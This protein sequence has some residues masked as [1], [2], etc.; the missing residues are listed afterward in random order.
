MDAK[1]SRR[2]SRSKALSRRL[3]VAVAGLR[4]GAD[5]VPIY[6]HHPDVEYVGIV[7]PERDKLDGVGN[8]FGVAR[9]HTDL[10]EAIHSGAY[11]AVHLVTPIPLHV[12]QSLAALQAGLHCACAV[13]MAASLTD[14][15]KIVT[16]QRKSRLNYMMME[17]AVYTR[18]F[19]YAR[20]L[21][22]SGQLGRI[23][24]LRG[25]HYQD[26]EGWPTYW[27]GLPPMH[28]ATHAV[29]PGFALANT[30]AKSVCC[31]G[32]GAMRKS[33]HRTY[34]N[35]FPVETAL[36][37][38]EKSPLAMEV[39]RSLFQTARGYAESFAVYGEKMTFEWPQLENEAPVVFALGKAD[40]QR[41]GA[42]VRSE[43]IQP[44]DRQDLLPPE[45]RR[46]T[47]RG[48][49][50]PCGP[51][52]P[53]EVGGGHHGSHPH[54]VHE[55]VRSIVEGR[56]PRIDAVTAAQWTAAGICA[57]Q[58]AMHGGRAVN[59]PSFE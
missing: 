10:N 41:R 58:S 1:H 9:R 4:F 24:L 26:M 8:R 48:S 15:R 50:N 35:P 54:L 14:M 45:I 3:R 20:D 34:G 59:V 13:P 7:E 56:K 57:H 46:F 42:P 51:E 52:K 39:T 33:L 17:T 30:H 55:F 2:P 49:Y 12:P 27:M 53:F 43:R 6:L 22:T 25:S 5:F 11:D 38:L 19:L 37:E 29:A 18:P 36:F 23:Q 31:L 16:A 28:Y 47:V 32:S 44:P 40:S 21:V